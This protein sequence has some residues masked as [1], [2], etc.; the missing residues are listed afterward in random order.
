MDEPPPAPLPAA[1]IYCCVPH[2]D[3]QD[4]S[5]VDRRELRC[6]DY[7]RAHGFGV[8]PAAV[9]ADTARAVWKPE[10]A[11][12]G[13]AA[14]WAAVERGQIRSLIIDSPGALIRH[15]AADLVRLLMSS[16]RRG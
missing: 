9:Y 4:Q 15:R 5:T 11:R 10:G 14:L 7:A 8:A 16:A 12:P 3:D 13:W 2:I 6:R 1:G